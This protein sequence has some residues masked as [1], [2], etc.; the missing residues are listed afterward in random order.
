M[1][2]TELACLRL[3]ATDPSPT[4]K[5]QLKQAQKAQSEYS[6]YPARFFRQVEDPEICYIVG[7]WESVTVHT[8]EWITSET[9]QKNLGLLKDDVAVAWMFHLDIDIFVFY[10]LNLTA[11]T[12]TLKPSTSPI[13]LDAPVIAI[14]RFFVEPANKD[15]FDA[16]SKAGVPHL[17]A[18]TAPFAYSG[19]LEN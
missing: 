18:Y 7:G 17:G 6:G 8:E 10:N 2:I 16:A 1:P 5:D 14:S 3:K 19:G 12:R 9:N 13:P 15:A 4:K 11:L